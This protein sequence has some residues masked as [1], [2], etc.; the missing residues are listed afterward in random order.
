MEKLRR[1]TKHTSLP[2]TWR[3]RSTHDILLRPS[4][5]PSTAQYVIAGRTRRCAYRTAPV[6]CGCLYTCGVCSFCAFGVLTASVSGAWQMSRG[7]RLGQ[8]G[9]RTVKHG[10][11][12]AD[13]RRH[14]SSTTL[15]RHTTQTG[16]TRLRVDSLGGS[17]ARRALSNRCDTLSQPRCD[18]I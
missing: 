14:L 15:T 5:L 2:H 3:H 6:C 17:M 1:S 4:A 11:S 13:K 16:M 10:S 7:W 18:V 9:A 8:Q 12:R